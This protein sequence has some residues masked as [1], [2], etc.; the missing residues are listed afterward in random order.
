MVCFFIWFWRMV[1]L[2]VFL[3]SVCDYAAIT[4]RL[5]LKIL[6]PQLGFFASILTFVAF[7]HLIGGVM[8][9]LYAPIIFL[10]GS[11]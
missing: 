10:D 7:V 9:G 8:D 2:W 3:R 1:G 4:P 11:R 5:H 6:K